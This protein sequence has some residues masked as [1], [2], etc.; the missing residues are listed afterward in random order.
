MEGLI[1]FESR[2]KKIVI[3]ES[4]NILVV[5]RRS[6]HNLVSRTAVS[7]LLFI[8]SSVTKLRF[9]HCHLGSVEARQMAS[10]LGTMNTTN[11]KLL[12]LDLSGNQIGDEGALSFAQVCF[13]YPNLDSV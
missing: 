1:Y 5:T 3:D 8:P 10:R 6:S 7:C 12:S 4:K 2:L 13:T 11:T 9:R